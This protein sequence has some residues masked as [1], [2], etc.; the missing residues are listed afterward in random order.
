[1]EAKKIEILNR[2]VEFHCIR[3]QKLYYAKYKINVYDAILR[4]TVKDMIMFAVNYNINKRW[5]QRMS[6]TY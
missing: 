4:E 6:L 5:N 1:M 2:I 3:T